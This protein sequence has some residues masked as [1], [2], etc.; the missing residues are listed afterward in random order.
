MTILDTLSGF[1]PR[2]KSKMVPQC[3]MVGFRHFG[4]HRLLGA[5][6]FGHVM[7]HLLYPYTLGLDIQQA[8]TTRQIGVLIILLL[9][10]WRSFGDV[11]R[12]IGE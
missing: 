9:Q 7:L 11:L 2:V 12:S 8:Q 3:M 10:Q 1:Y 4:R 5:T 6:S